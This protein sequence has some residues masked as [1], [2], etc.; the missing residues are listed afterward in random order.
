MNSNQ[1]KWNLSCDITE[2]WDLVKPRGR[3]WLLSQAMTGG[4]A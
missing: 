4:E 1:T 3:E 2:G